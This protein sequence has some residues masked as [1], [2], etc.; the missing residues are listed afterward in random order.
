TRI[1]KRWHVR[2]DRFCTRA[3][4]AVIAV[5]RHTADHLIEIEKAPPEKVHVIYNGIDYD[6]VTV[7]DTAAPARLRREFA[8]ESAHLLLV[9]ARLHPEKGHEYLF[10]AL[11]LIQERVT[12]PVVLLVA[13]EGP[14]AN[15]YRAQVRSL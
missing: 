15:A 10:S 6:R 9:V 8:G 14:F 12:R 4:H 2:L 1:G 11:P 13:G 7:S 5:S 3:S